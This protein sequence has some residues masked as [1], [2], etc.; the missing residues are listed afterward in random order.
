MPVSATRGL[1][2]TKYRA[3]SITH[4]SADQMMASIAMTILMILL[5]FLIF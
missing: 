2:A 5:I 4:V 1:P 3:M